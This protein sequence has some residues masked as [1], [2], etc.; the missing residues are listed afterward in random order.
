MEKFTVYTGKSVPLM[1][2]NI[3]TDQLIPKQFLKAVDKKGF[4]KNLMFEWRYLND[5]YDE[6]PDFVF[7]KPEYRDATILVTGDNFGSGSSREH[8]AWA[9]EDYGFRCV[10]AGS[11]SDIHYN[12]E[13]KN[14]MLPIVQPLE[15][16]QKLAALP[17]GEEITIDL[18]NQVIKSSAG[19]FPFDID[20]EWKRKLVEGLD[21]IGITLQYEDLIAA[22]E[23]QRPAYWQ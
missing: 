18:P 6:N 2:D 12:N 22:Y 1:N 5:D 10:I 14:G 13:L 16:R 20:H 23:K 19:E 3:D 8:A 7:N 9:L 11:F 15:V 17:A 4:G 21:D